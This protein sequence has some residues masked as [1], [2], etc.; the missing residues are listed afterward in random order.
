MIAVVVAASL[1][2]LVVGLVIGAVATRRHAY[3]VC[4]R[5][6][7]ADRGYRP[8]IADGFNGSPPRQRRRSPDD[9]FVWRHMPERP[10]RPVF[11]QP[12]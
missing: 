2:S 10:A 11:D 4:Q 3:L 8:A 1:T 7:L 9:K 5:Q 6:A 12:R